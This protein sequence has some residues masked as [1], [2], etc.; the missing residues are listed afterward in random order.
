MNSH[1]GIQHKNKI[2]KLKVGTDI[3]CDGAWLSGKDIP[4]H[5]MSVGRY[6]S[7]IWNDDTVGV[8]VEVGAVSRRI[9]SCHKLLTYHKTTQILHR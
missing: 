6:R 4:G 9:R 1:L 7:H 8:R 3:E 5:K 2:E